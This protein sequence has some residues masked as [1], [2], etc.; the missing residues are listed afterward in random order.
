MKK[1]FVAFLLLTALSLIGSKSFAYDSWNQAQD[2]DYYSNNAARNSS[3]EGARAT[4][5]CGFDRDCGSSPPPVDLS[6]AGAHPTPQLLRTSD[7]NNNPY[8]PQQY[9]SLRHTPPPPLP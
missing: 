8:I 4:S 6:G 2:T 5:G 9:R 3:M 1:I 7:D